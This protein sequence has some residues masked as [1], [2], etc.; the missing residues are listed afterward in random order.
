MKYYTIKVNGVSYQVEVEENGAP[1]AVPMSA[2]VSAPVPAASPATVPAPA[3]APVPAPVP[4]PAPAAPAPVRAD[5]TGGEMIKAPMPGTI[6]EV[7]VQ[8]G[9][10]VTRGQV[11][12]ILEAMKMEN[13]IVAP[14][15]GTVAA[16]AVAKGS[17]VNAGDPMVSLA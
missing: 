12:C 6:I 13:E 8:L 17:T 9:E 11:L 16:I 1:V 2:P 5:I 7:T 4:A 14:R 10:S 3:A 15:D